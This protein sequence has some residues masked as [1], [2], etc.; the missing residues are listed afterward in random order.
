MSAFPSIASVVDEC[1]HSFSSSHLRS[2]S[3][4]SLSIC[5]ND[6][7]SDPCCYSRRPIDAGAG[8]WIASVRKIEAVGGRRRSPPPPYAAV[9][10][11]TPRFRLRPLSVHL[12]SPIAIIV[13]I[14]AVVA[15]PLIPYVSIQTL[16]LLSSSSKALETSSSSSCCRSYFLRSFQCPV[17]VACCP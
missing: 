3:A 7:L 1:R 4:S 14:V 9:I 8:R 11:L 6:T 16:S 5:K 12:C 2:R 13:I 17:P 10:P 15:V